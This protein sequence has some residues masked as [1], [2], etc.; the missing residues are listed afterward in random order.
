M[1]RARSKMTRLKSKIKRVRSK[2]RRVR[3]NM[4]MRMRSNRKLTKYGW[5]DPS[6]SMGEIDG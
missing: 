2:L 6:C 3:S 4:T 5:A 1:N